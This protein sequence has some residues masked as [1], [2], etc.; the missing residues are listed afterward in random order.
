[1][2]SWPR[3]GLTAPCCRDCSADGWV[4]V[5]ARAVRGAARCWEGRGERLAGSASSARLSLGVPTKVTAGRPGSTE[6]MEVAA[7]LGCPGAQQD[8]GTPALCPDMV[9]VSW[10]RIKLEMVPKQ[11]PRSHLREL[12][13]LR[14]PPSC[15]PLHP[16]ALIPVHPSLCI[17]PRA[18]IPVHAWAPVCVP[19]PL[20]I[21]VNACASSAPCARGLSAAHAG[22]A[23]CPWDQ[24]PGTAGSWRQQPLIPSRCGC[25]SRLLE[26]PRGFRGRGSRWSRDKAAAAR[27]LHCS[28]AVYGRRAPRSPAAPQQPR[29]PCALSVCLSLAP[30][31]PCSSPASPLLCLPCWGHWGHWGFWGYWGTGDTGGTG[32]TGD[33][34]DTR[35][36]GDSGNTVTGPARPVPPL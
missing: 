10:R 4:P 8:E 22:P 31:R 19:H 11:P 21:R 23:S 18:S 32:N 2:Q 12:G 14:A 35:D 16:C 28:W 15:A 1:M 13:W 30:A 7:G 24:A 29:S 3:L 6:Q 33:S 34:G 9:C 27:L 26:R 20:C 25:R 17:H 5:L 36:T